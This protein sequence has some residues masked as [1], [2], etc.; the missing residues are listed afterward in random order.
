MGTSVDVESSSR[1]VSV[2]FLGWWLASPGHVLALKSLLQRAGVSAHLLYVFSMPSQSWIP[3]YLA[4]KKHIWTGSRLLSHNSHAFLCGAR[5]TTSVFLCPTRHGE[6]K[7]G[8][9][10]GPLFFPSTLYPAPLIHPFKDSLLLS[11]LSKLS[12][13]PN[14]KGH[15]ASKPSFPHRWKKLLKSNCYI[16]RFSDPQ[17][18]SQGKDPQHGLFPYRKHIHESV[19]EPAPSWE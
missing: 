4:L 3:H 16:P 17:V 14:L 5:K 7:N 12:V 13:P 18:L 2:I 6:N 11:E 9:G 10:V 19:P 8:V 1:A 15:M